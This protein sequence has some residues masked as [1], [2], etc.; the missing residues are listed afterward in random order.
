MKGT[1]ALPYAAPDQN[2]TF[3]SIH[4]CPPWQNTSHPA[5]IERA[6]GKGKVIWCAA[7]LEYD[8]REAFKTLFKKIVGEN[9]VKKYD[10][11]AGK[12]IECV[13][14]EDDDLSLISLCDLQYDETKTS[15]TIPFTVKSG[16]APKTF[17]NLGE[18]KDVPFTYDERTGVCSATLSVDDFAMFEIVY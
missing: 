3:A 6:Y 5:L 2:D 11:K 7:E 1:V 17:R 18:N 8:E 13:V 12:A 10:C 9:V 14:F 16:K 15:G 4:S